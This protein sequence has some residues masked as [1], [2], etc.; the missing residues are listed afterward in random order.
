MSFFIVSEEILDSPGFCFIDGL[1]FHPKLI[2]WDLN[3][4]SLSV[5]QLRT[6]TT[7]WLIPRI[8]SGLVHPSYKWINP[9]KIPF[10]TGV[11]THLR[12]VGSS[13][14]SRTKSSYWIPTHPGPGKQFASRKPWLMASSESSLMK[15]T[16][17][18]LIMATSLIYLFE[19]VISPLMVMF[20]TPWRIHV[21]KKTWCAMDPI[22][23]PPL[24]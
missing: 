8:V 14:P 20:N 18:L 12:F 19:H 13:P 2:P 16:A 6:S 11:I 7:W 10:I 23:I 15:P 22:H 17:R 5:L 1:K 4:G 24:C 21:C 9:T 3:Q